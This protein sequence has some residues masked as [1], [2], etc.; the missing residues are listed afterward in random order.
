ML[1][2]LMEDGTVEYMPIHKALK[3]QEFKSYG[4]LE[5][6]SNIVEIATG[7]AQAN[8]DGSGN[9]PGWN[10]VFA[11]NYD[12]DYYDIGDIVENKIK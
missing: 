11:I 7:M 5:N 2:F 10:T 3:S 9:G 1:Y 8:V 4:K 6:V 12:G